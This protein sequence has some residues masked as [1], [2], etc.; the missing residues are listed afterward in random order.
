MGQGKQINQLAV[1]IVQ[2]V[3]FMLSSTAL[4]FGL[5]FVGGEKVEY[6]ICLAAAPV[7]FV[8]LCLTSMV[9][10]AMRSSPRGSVIEKVR[11]LA[12]TQV[13]KEVKG[14]KRMKR[15]SRALEK[16]IMVCDGAM[17]TELQ[18]TELYKRVYEQELEPAMPLE[19]WNIRH[20]DEV[21]LIHEAYVEVGAEIILTNTL[22]ANRKKLER[23]DKCKY[24]DKLNKAGVKIARRAC[25][26]RDVFVCGNIG[27]TGCA[28]ELF[29]SRG[30]G[31]RTKEELYDVFKEQGVALWEA[32]VDAIWIEAMSYLDEAVLAV[33]AAR[34]KV[35]VPVICSM[36]FRA[37]P[38]SRP[39]DFRTFWGDTVEHIVSELKEA[40]ANALGS[41][42][43]E[44]VEEMPRLARRMRELTDLPLVFEV[45]AGLPKVVPEE[46]FKA[47]YPLGPGP[48][49]EIISQVVGEGGNIVGGCCGTTPEHIAAAWERVKAVM[50]R[51]DRNGR[52]GV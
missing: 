23:Y 5:Y 40:G 52:R 30:D 31:E 35:K 21:Q 2:V 28:E 16:K 26:G 6:L 27:P 4:L 10:K 9:G 17:G 19:W 49:G 42:C 45:N 38:A 50:R 51:Q 8:V 1:M 36:S 48:F 15:F 14:D 11:V 34:E 20:Q 32:G 39:D 29:N 25:V 47:V 37:A 41:N 46:N 7:F 3:V 12:R 33:K 13:Q 44:V 22:G 43:G 24:V 18:K